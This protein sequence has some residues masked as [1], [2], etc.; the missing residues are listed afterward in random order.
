MRSLILHSTSTAQWHSLLSEAQQQSAIYLKEDLES[1]LVFLLMRFAEQPN[2]AASVLGLDFLHS[3]Q[4]LT[5]PQRHYLLK[6]VGDKCLLYAGLFPGRAKRRRVKVSYFIKLGQTAYST[7]S[8]YQFPEEPLFISLC[9]EFTNLMD[10]LQ[11]MREGSSAIDLLD[12][13]ELWHETG[14]KAAWKRWNQAKSALPIF[15]DKKNH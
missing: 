3:C 5:D 8:N 12:S 4:S 7:L 15:S 9:Q 10:V 1:Y 14:S 6:E 11:S 13:L 2:L